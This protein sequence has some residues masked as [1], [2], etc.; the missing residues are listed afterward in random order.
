[1]NIRYLLIRYMLWLRVRA[2]LK[3]GIKNK[4]TPRVEIQTQRKTPNQRCLS[5]HGRLQ[6]NLNILPKNSDSK[7]NVANY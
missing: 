2:A 4:K 5:R 3:L 1:M 6:A 7:R